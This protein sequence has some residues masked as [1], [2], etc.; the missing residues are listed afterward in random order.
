MADRQQ[1]SPPVLVKNVRVFDGVSDKLSKPRSVYMADRKIAEEPRTAVTGTVVIDG[2][3]RV[4]MPGLSD[5]HCHLFL[6]GSTVAELMTAPTGLP[7]YHAVAQAEQMLMR[8]FTTI[9]DTGGDVGALKQ[10]IDAGLFPGPRIYPSQ[11]MISQ[12]SGHGDFS[13]IYDSATTFGGPRPRAEQLGIMRVAD[14]RSQVLAAVR[15]QL[16]KG[17]SQIKVMAGGGVSSDYDPLETLQYTEDEM[18]AAVQAAADYGTYVLVHVFNVDG[19]R[20]AIA[21][22][23]KSIEHAMLADEDTIKLMAEKDVWFSAQPLEESDHHFATANSRKKNDDVCAGVEQTLAWARK[24]GAKVAFGTDMLFDPAKAP[25]QSELFTRLVTKFGFTPIQALKIGTSG[26]AE[27]FR[28]S[29]SR[30]PYKEAPLGVIQTG[31]W[32]DVLLVDGDPT[33]DIGLL[34]EPEKNLA[35]IIK[36]GRIHKNQLS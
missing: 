1:T 34:A 14:G 21:A 19:I 30:D 7:Y 16:K 28:M 6:V 15:E 35:V 3:G 20:R 24:H 12:T 17:A 2:G 5:A 8:G 9:R 13:S 32:A 11:A 25:M 23:V 33:R 22:G 4:L 18:Q 31:A 10:V 29:G 36:N 26:N 27:L